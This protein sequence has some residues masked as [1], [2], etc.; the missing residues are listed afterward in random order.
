MQTRS[1]VTLGAALIVGYALATSLPARAATVLITGANSGL[2]LEFAKQYA[3]KDWTVIATHR[4]ESRQG[5]RWP[6]P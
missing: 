5:R 2:G 3:A 4:R 6:P 1:M